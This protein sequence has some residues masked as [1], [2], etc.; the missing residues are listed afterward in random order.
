[1]KKAV[2]LVLAVFAFSIGCV[3][4]PPENSS[5]SAP[6]P[7]AGEARDDIT[8]GSSIPNWLGAQKGPLNVPVLPAIKDFQAIGIITVKTQAVE[9]LG[10]DNQY[11]W[12]GETVNYSMLIEEAKKLN[13]HAIINIVI[14]YTDKIQFIENITKLDSRHVWSHDEMDKISRGLLTESLTE[15][16]RFAVEKSHVLTRTYSGSALA[17]KYIDGVNFFEVEQVRALAP[18][19]E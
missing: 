5:V 4:A 6:S 3:S 7:K 10:A 15:E 19:Y 17:I 1:M 16:G 13:A 2:F 9:K 18:Q 8:G 12:E 14:D 11:H